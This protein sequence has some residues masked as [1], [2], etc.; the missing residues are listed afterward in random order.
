MVD[1]VEDQ[2]HI[3]T[4]ESV[5]RRKNFRTSAS[6]VGFTLVEMLV[7]I[8]IIGILT[9]LLLPAI[10]KAREAARSAKCQ[11]N[12]KNFGIGFLKHS[13]DRPDGS[14]CSGAFD[15]ELD[16]I[17]TEIGWIADVTQRGML[18]HEMRCPSNSVAASSAV[19]QMLTMPIADF[20]Q[21]VIGDRLGREPFIDEKK[22]GEIPLWSNFK[23]S[24]TVSRYLRLPPVK[25]KDASK[26]LDKEIESKI[27]IPLEELVVTKWICGD[28]RAP[29]LGRP[30]MI[31]TAKKEFIIRRTSLLESLGL[32]LAGLQSDSIALINFAVREFSDVWSNTEVLE[33]N[34]IDEIQKELSRAIC[35]IDAGASSTHLTLVSVEAH[36]SMSIETGGEDLTFQIASSAKTTRKDAE[37][38]KRNPTQLPSLTQQYSPIEA[39]LDT[40]RFRLETMYQDALKQDNPFN[41]VSTWCV[42]GAWQTYQ[43]IR[44]VMT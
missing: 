30:A 19:E 41:P 26:L 17:P 36:W 28:K 4:S 43:W 33:S 6:H 16:G 37:S 15:L 20:T 38:Y 29:T 22:P 9:T 32:K 35:I 3:Y 12:L 24:H 42:G 11:S 5:D 21:K 34:E 1:V 2:S 18:P 27:P 31:S 8:S 7:V 25:T 13:I 39:D 10:S 40:M 23:N 44:R 14:F